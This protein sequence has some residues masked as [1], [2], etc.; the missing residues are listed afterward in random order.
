LKVI[1]GGVQMTERTLD[2]DNRYELSIDSD[3]TLQIP[4]EVLR[5]AGF[6]PGDAVRVVM[7][8]GEVKL[9]PAR[10]LVPEITADVMK[11]M[12]EDGITVEELLSGLE[13]AREAAFRETYG[14]P[15]TD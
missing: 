3:G 6:Q 15:S 9:R 7:V 12:A 13:D 4:P 11:M 1:D 2:P 10:L 8:D 5:E 14:R